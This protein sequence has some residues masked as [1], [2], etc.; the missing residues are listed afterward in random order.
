MGTTASRESGGVGTC[1]EA[2]GE[3]DGGDGDEGEAE[4]LGGGGVRRR[5]VEARMGGGARRPWVAAARGALVR[6]ARRRWV[7]AALRSEERRVGKECLL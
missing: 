6:G 2:R 4:A 3:L 1:E 5:W 7:A